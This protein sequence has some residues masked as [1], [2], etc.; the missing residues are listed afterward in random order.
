MRR[1]T[2]EEE[3]CCCS[4]KL[5]LNNEEKP[6]IYRSTRCMCVAKMRGKEKHMA[7]NRKGERNTW[8]KEDKKGGCACMK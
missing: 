2:R 7:K 5:T 3:Y 6:P 4:E 8:I 1:I